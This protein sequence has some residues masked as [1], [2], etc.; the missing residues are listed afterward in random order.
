MLLDDIK[1]AMFKAIRAGLKLWEG[2]EG[3]RDGLQGP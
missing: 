3:R 1:A 2:S